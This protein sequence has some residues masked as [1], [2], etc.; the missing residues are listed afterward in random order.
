[1]KGSDKFIIT[2]NEK[3]MY[4]EALASELVYLRAKADISQE[5]LAS[6]I[7]VSRQTYIAIERQTKK[8]SW[9]SYIAIVF[10]YSSNY[11]TK[12]LIRAIS[13]PYDILRR[14][15]GVEE[16]SDYDF[17][18]FLDEKEG[19]IIDKLDDQARR[20]IRTVIMVEYA[21]CSNK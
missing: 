11:K 4:I 9:S 1:M 7:G 6:A 13:Y 3:N 2:N 16:E 19:F 21:R 14:F 18:S 17:T 15:N 8:M 20:S 10:F 5:E 12:E